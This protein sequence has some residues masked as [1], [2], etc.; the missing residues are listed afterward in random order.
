MVICWC[1][2]IDSVVGFL[3][4]WLL[5]FSCLVSVCMCLV[6]GVLSNV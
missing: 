2:L 1:W 4:N 3:F 6:D 5:I